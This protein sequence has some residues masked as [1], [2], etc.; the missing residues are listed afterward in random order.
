MLWDPSVHGTCWS[1]DTLQPLSYTNLA[2]NITTDLFFAILIPAPMLWGLNVNQRTR[3]SLLAILG[4][5]VFACAACFVKLG[6]IVNYGKLGD[7]L[8]DS[9]NITIWTIVENNIGIIAGSLPTL[10]PLFKTILGS[11]YGKGSR[12]TGPSGNGYYGKGTISGSKSNWQSLGS[13]RPDPTDEASSERAFNAGSEEFEMG[14]RGA[15]GNKPVVFAEV[16][17]KSS[18]ESFNHAGLHANGGIT[19]TTTTTRTTMFSD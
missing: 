16:H 14:N 1:K 7:W 9:R 8:W 19:K 5:G 18:L 15:A 17:A 11:T 10:R 3:Y 12:K 2:L 4:L 6:S 13:R